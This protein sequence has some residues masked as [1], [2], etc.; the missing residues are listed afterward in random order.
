MKDHHGPAEL[1]VPGLVAFAPPAFGSV[2][3][4]T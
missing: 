4:I 1:G 3:G 2:T